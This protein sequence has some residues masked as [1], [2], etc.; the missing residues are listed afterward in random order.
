LHYLH[1]LQTLGNSSFKFQVIYDVTH[2][3]T[4]RIFNAD[5]LIWNLQTKSSLLR[6]R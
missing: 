1:L 5:F 3:V 2:Y 6:S 4:H